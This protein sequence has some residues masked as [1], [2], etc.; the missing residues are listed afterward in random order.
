MLILYASIPKNLGYKKYT[1]KYELQARLFV[2]F[3]E[4][5]HEVTLEE[6][7]EGGIPPEVVNNR[8]FM[9]RVLLD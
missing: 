3:R 2:H 6:E 9:A 8:E 4:K 5:M 7:P 1:L